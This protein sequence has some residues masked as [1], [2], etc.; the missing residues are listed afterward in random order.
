VEAEEEEETFEMEAPSSARRQ[1]RAAPRQKVVF[2]F[3]ADLKD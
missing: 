3:I 2:Q 1:R